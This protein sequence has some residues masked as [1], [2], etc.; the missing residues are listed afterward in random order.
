MAGSAT[1]ASAARAC[2]ST[3]APDRGRTHPAGAIEQL[4]AELALQA[5]DL[6]AHTRLGDVQPLRGAREAPVVGNGD[7]VLELAQLHN[8]SF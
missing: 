4:L 5:A 2:G 6:R 3:A 8:R 7:E 1:A